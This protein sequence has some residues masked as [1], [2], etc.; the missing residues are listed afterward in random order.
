ML[1]WTGWL[2]A[3]V[4]AVLATT[5]AAAVGPPALQMAA[6]A[7]SAAAISLLAIRDHQKLKN[8]G[9]P[10]IAVATSSA[11]YFALIWAWGGLTL[12]ITYVFIIEQRWP[13]WWQ[14]LLGFAFAALASIGFAQMLDRDRTSGSTD[15]TLVKFGRTLVKVQI[16]GMIAGVISLF[17]DGKF[18]RPDTYADWAGCNIFFFGALA[19]A[20][21]SLDALRS[22]VQ[23]HA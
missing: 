5:L 1:T 20:A 3:L 7:A 6:V 4:A 14:F 18:P 2:L 21:I 13:E 9:E 15:L 23:A 12:L 22:P 19:I 17:I 16:V 8:S 11:R 10:A